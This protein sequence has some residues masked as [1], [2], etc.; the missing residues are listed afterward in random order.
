MLQFLWESEKVNSLDTIFSR[1][2]SRI[3]YTQSCE[4]SMLLIFWLNSIILKK[5][6]N[7]ICFTHFRKLTITITTLLCVLVFCKYF[8]ASLETADEMP[9]T[10]NVLFKYLLLKIFHI[11]DFL[12]TL[13]HIGP[14]IIWFI[15]PYG[16]TNFVAQAVGTRAKI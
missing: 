15:Q 4:M 6:K 9:W 12:K 3:N 10:I 5:K 1:H 13:Y 2:T 8:I 7:I 16:A 11:R 14:K